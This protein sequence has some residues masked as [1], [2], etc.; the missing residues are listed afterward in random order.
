MNIKIQAK[1][2]TVSW[3]EIRQVIWESHKEN[4]ERGL[5]MRYP[6]LSGEEMKEVVGDDGQCF[7]AMDGDKVVGTCSYTLKNRKSWYGKNG[8]VAYLLLAA[9]LPEYHGRGIYSRLLACREQ[10]ILNAGINTLEMDTAEK[11][12]HVR[13]ILRSHGFMPVE[14][15]AYP[16]GNHYS[17]VMIKEL[18][19]S[20]PNK[21]ECT[22]RYVW[23][24]IKTKLRYKPGKVK[25]FG[26]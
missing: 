1:P 20:H 11:N 8:P 10:S 13:R 16:Y 23:S 21:V 18:G 22:L 6:S 17:V 3:E 12:K 7:V 15:R 9:I 19:S 26:I 4:R 25:R 14:L 2:E 24:Y 5:H